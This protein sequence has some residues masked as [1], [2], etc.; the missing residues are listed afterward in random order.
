MASTFLSFLG[1]NNYL[2]CI[3]QFP[4][5][6]HFQTKYTQ[7]AVIKKHYNEINKF[8]FFLTEDA[9]KNNWD[10]EGKL[11]DELD[12]LK[13]NEVKTIDIPNGF[14]NNQ[15]L[16]IFTLLVQNIENEATLIIDVTH[17]FRSLPITLSSV[18]EYLKKVKNVTIKYIYYGAFEVLGNPRD[19]E[20]KPVEERIAPI[21]DITYLSAINDWTSAI[22]YFLEYGN[23]D[24][25]KDLS[26]TAI[27]PILIETQ[28]KDEVAT[29]IRY[30]IN[31]LDKLLN[32]LYTCR[33]GEIF[34]V[35]GKFNDLNESLNKVI[36]KEDNAILPQIVEPFKRI[37]E[38]LQILNGDEDIT[39]KSIKLVKWCI[40]Y[41]W[42][43]QGFTLLQE[44]LI[45][46]V[47]IKNK[48]DYFEKQERES[49]SSAFNI[50][51]NNIPECKWKGDIDK[52]RNCT[53]NFVL[54]K[55][56]AVIYND[57]SDYRND[58][59][60]GG[61]R[62]NSRKA[63]DLKQKLNYFYERTLEILLR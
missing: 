19:V 29:A 41:N 57:L 17:S 24:K 35:I 55:E 5:N 33:I 60:H 7:I 32:A 47:L 53:E 12:K 46:Y 44:N 30:V 38:K 16:Y 39:F 63:D 2:G 61:Y 4:D 25:L 51:K 13:I 49:L 48:K 27:K 6:Q 11:K 36:N 54:V 1:T 42:I 8:L 31:I 26:H 10:G 22:D 62:Q 3:Y 28:G 9:K 45:S 52:I 14:D 18:L 20:K 56:L 15:L 50:I 40:D 37:Q 58:I 43:Q 23:I 34:D 21:L 59:N